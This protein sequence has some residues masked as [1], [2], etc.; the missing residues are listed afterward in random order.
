MR[1][2]G[3]QATRQAGT[4]P[5][6]IPQG[7][8]VVADR[9]AI[10]A[11]CVDDLNIGMADAVIKAAPGLVGDPPAIG[12]PDRV[13]EPSVAALRVVGCR[14]CRWRRWRPQGGDRAVQSGHAE[15]TVTFHQ[16]GP[17][18]IGRPVGRRAEVAAD[19][20]QHW[21]CAR[22]TLTIQIPSFRIVASACPVGD[23][24]PDQAPANA[25]RG[26]PPASATVQRSRAEGQEREH[27]TPDRTTA[28]RRPEGDHL[29]ER[30]PRTSSRG[31]PPA[32]P[33]TYTLVTLS[34]LEVRSKA[35][36]RPSGDQSGRASVPDPL[37]R[38]TRPLP[39]GRIVY[40]SERISK[41]SLPLTT[42]PAGEPLDTP[43]PKQATK[44]APKSRRPQ[45]GSHGMSAR[46]RL[47]TRVPPPPIRSTVLIAHRQSPSAGPVFGNVTRVEV[48]L[49]I[50]RPAGGGGSRLRF[51]CPITSW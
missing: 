13:T 48:T 37:V 15:E 30:A 39:F 44:T 16:Q 5:S 32:S 4:S 19:A 29:G 1:A 45:H 18:G 43:A 2:T 11:F 50:S 10:V 24:S 36:Q 51:R 42:G 49:R 47:Q 20:A 7:V 17:A 46:A 28:N 33:T 27:L 12:R 41:A 23:Q 25:S 40:R 6:R 9:P 38:C 8:R 35:I 14:R 21:D 34:A 26:L 3:S 22:L 31:R